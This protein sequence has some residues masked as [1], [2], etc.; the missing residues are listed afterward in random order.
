MEFNI[1]PILVPM[2]T[3]VLVSAFIVILIA[4]L[5]VWLGPSMG[6]LV[7]GL[8]VGLGPGFYFLID[9]L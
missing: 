2:V 5:V 9:G 6:G 3:R 8:P 1:E 7:A 4:K